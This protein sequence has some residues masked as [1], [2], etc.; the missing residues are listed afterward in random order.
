MNPLVR[1]G[2]TLS[3]RPLAA[4]S[5]AMAPSGRSSKRTS[6]TASG[7]GNGG[8]GWAAWTIRAPA[9]RARVSVKKGPGCEQH[10]LG[11]FLRV[12]M[13]AHGVPPRPTGRA[14]R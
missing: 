2:T 11:Y 5:M 6:R 8:A 12:V 1:G 14:V 4:S 10:A 7:G 13:V 9:A 3:S